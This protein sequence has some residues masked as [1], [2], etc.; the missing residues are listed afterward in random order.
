MTP[1]LFATTAQILCEAGSAVR[2]G[3]LCRERGARR[4][5]IV[6]DP[7]ITRLG[8]LDA[9]LPGFAEAGVAVEVFDQVVADPPEAVVL[10]AVAQA[11]VLQADLLVGFGGGSS[12][13]VAKLVALLAHPQCN[14]Q[15][16]D[17]YGV[18]NAKG[19]RLPLIQVPTTA[20]TGSEV[21]QISIITTGE[22]TKTG[23]VSPLLLPDLALLDADLTLGLPP[24][25]TAATG[26]DAMVHAIEAYTSK[27]RKNPLSDMLAREALRLLATNLDEAVHNGSNREARQAM[28]LGALLAG[29]A[30]ANAPVAA[31]HALAYPLGGHFHI[32]HGLSNAL[33]LP[34]VIAFN[35]PAAENLYAEL[36]PLL[37]PDLQPGSNARLTEQLVAALAELSPRCQLP[38]RLRDAGVPEDSLPMLARDAMLQ[39]RLLVNNPRALAEADALAIY[40]Q[41]F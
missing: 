19:Q 34:A 14:Q 31:V 11:R 9:V 10:A 41:A 39:Q 37:V 38:S 4:V 13:D 21:T 29:Q 1:F 6:T 16:A 36:A 8:M 33:V 12:M 20:G 22:T 3:A 40:R 5:L 24:A 7:G 30:F 23:V 17:I 26:I 32:P 25:V 15:L 18:G 27:L 28:L 35:A 2:L